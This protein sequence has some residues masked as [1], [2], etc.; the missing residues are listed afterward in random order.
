MNRTISLA[1]I[2][3]YFLIICYTWMYTEYR[4]KKIYQYFC[5]NTNLTCNKNQYKLILNLYFLHETFRYSLKMFS[6]M[7]CKSQNQVSFSTFSIQFQLV[8][9]ACVTKGN[10]PFL[11]CSPCMWSRA[12]GHM[13][14]DMFPVTLCRIVK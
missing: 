11:C 7:T 5:F 6:L 14:A 2:F 1:Y 8:R 10:L 12:A 13:Y 3:F 4:T 9:D